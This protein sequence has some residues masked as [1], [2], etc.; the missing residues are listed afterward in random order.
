[1]IAFLLS[2]K[3]CEERERH[4]GLKPTMTIRLFLHLPPMYP[5]PGESWGILGNAPTIIGSITEPLADGQ[6]LPWDASV[7]PVHY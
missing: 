5:N 3:Y 6:N 2:P 7:R 4:Q 1:M